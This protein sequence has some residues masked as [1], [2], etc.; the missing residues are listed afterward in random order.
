MKRTNWLLLLLIVLTPGVA[1]AQDDLEEIRRQLAAERRKNQEQQRMLEALEERVG[2]AEAQ[3]APQLGGAGGEFGAAEEPESEGLLGSGALYDKGFFGRAGRATSLGGYIDLEYFDIQGSNNTFRNHRFVPFIYSQLSE[4]V[5]LAAEIEFE[6]GGSDSPSGDGETKVEFAA[7]DVVFDEAFGVRAGALLSPL[8]RFNLYHD[9]PMNDLTD[10]PLVDRLI[11]PSTLTEA[12][13][14]FFG[15]IYP[16]EEST[17]TY[18]I[19]LV[20]GFVGLEEDATAAT[21]FKSN[22]SRT[23]GLRDARGS[24]KSDNNN[25]TST[26][27]RI[28]Y[29]PFLGFEVGASSHAGKYDD[30]GSNWMVISALDITLDGAA[31]CE[32]LSG[33][34]FMGEIVRAEISRNSLARAS[35]VPDDMWGFYAQVNYHFMVGPLEDLLPQAFGGD[36][37]FTAATRLDH[38]ELGNQRTQRLTLGINYRWT[39]DTVFKFD[40]QF[41]FE[42]WHRDRV[43]NDAVVVSVASYF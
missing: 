2:A 17:L 41:N 20:N 26:V 34:E 37:T 36:A 32:C 40:Y 35:D 11:I 28:A 6:Y 9:S 3:A 25:S 21:G 10:R 33:W 16:D 8:G 7:L 27:A 1:A 30:K 4:S 5:R 38:V 29:S 18:E 23:S 19:Y 13:A 42:N 39:E 31:V 43:D 24:L 14:G 15:T 22:I 12:G